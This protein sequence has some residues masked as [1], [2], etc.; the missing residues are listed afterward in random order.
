[1]EPLPPEREGQLTSRGAR[2]SADPALAQLSSG[3]NG[4]QNHDAAS[5]MLLPQD[6]HRHHVQGLNWRT[7]LSNAI[8][9]GFCLEIISSLSSIAV[10][11]ALLA[12]LYAYSDRALP[13]WPWGITVCECTSRLTSTEADPTAQRDCLSSR[14]GGEKH[15]TF[16]RCRRH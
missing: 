3:N 12:I 2:R 10:T 9:N 15:A 5:Q 14:D 11:I 8:S 13:S 4:H 16:G 7:R 6:S 1:M